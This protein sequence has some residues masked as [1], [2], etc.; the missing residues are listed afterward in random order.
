MKFTGTIEIFKI[1]VI[2]KI[3]IPKHLVPGTF[4]VRALNDSLAGKY[5]RYFCLIK[6]K[7][8]HREIQELVRVDNS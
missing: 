4:V 6:G 8:S 1:I 5:C 3:K 7:L 2:P